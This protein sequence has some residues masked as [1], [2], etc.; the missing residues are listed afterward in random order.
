MPA[1]L[2]PARQPALPQQPPAVRWSHLPYQDPED[3][4]EGHGRVPAQGHSLQPKVS[5][6]SLWQVPEDNGSHQPSPAAGAAQRLVRDGKISYLNLRLDKFKKSVSIWASFKRG[7]WEQLRCEHGNDERGE[8]SRHLH[9][10]ELSRATCGAESI[11]EWTQLLPEMVPCSSQKPPG[12][13]NKG[14]YFHLRVF[15]RSSPSLP[16]STRL[17]AEGWLQRVP[18]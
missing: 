2:P 7:S 11:W 1:C 18:V 5:T 4:S 17:D 10:P 13:I 14:N 3:V 8:V 16:S 15:P 6:E 9:T 12:I